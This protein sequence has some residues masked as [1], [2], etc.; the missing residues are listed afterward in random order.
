MPGSVNDLTFQFLQANVDTSAVNSMTDTVST[1][2]PTANAVLAA[3]VTPPAGTYNVTVTSYIGGTTVAAT[4]IN[5]MRIRVGAAAIG[6]IINP[7]PGT[8]GAVSAVNTTV[9]VKCDG[10]QNIDVIAVGAGTVG[11]IYG[12]NIVATRVL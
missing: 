5:N 8:S 7:V 4:E 1:T 10:T 9:R 2:S 11:S 3:V 12:V 6:R